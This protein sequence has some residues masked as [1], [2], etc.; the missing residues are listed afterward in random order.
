MSEFGDL[1]ELFYSARARYET[2][3]LEAHERR[4]YRLRIEAHE[5]AQPQQQEGRTVSRLS[6]GYAGHDIPEEGTRRN[7]RRAELADVHRRRAR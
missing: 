3:R 7:L 6:Y 5:R 1:L 2:V 4:N